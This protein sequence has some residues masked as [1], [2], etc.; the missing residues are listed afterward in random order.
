MFITASTALLT[1]LG[2][3]NPSSAVVYKNPFV[4]FNIVLIKCRAL[5]CIGLETFLILT[6]TIK[7][8][9]TV[10]FQLVVQQQQRA[11]LGCQSLQLC[12]FLQCARVVCERFSCLCPFLWLFLGTT[13]DV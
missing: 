9:C 1:S 2:I 5:N 7:F 12:R 13:A 3:N 8:S 6:L 10:T 4:G 11:N